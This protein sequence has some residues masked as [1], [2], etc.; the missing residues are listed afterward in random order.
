M[1]EGGELDIWNPHTQKGER[2]KWRWGEKKET[3]R[4]N[5]AFGH[6]VIILLAF[7]SFPCRRA[8]LCEGGWY[9]GEKGKRGRKKEISTSFFLSPLSLAYELPAWFNPHLP[10]LDYGVCL[11][12]REKNDLIT[13]LLRW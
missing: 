12:E 3:G 11:G 8:K 9:G 5:D 10:V 7:S 2:K 1:D 13:P 6:N 4:K